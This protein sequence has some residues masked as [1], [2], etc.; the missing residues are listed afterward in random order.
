M[1]SRPDGEVEIGK[2]INAFTRPNPL[3]QNHW[4]NPAIVPQSSDSDDDVGEDYL[5]LASLFIVKETRLNDDRPR[6]PLG[7]DYNYVDRRSI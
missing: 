5:C 1:Y 4:W 6:V 2:M 3:V 7:L